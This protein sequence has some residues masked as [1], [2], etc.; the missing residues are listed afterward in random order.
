MGSSRVAEDTL[1][2]LCL[3]RECLYRCGN[4]SGLDTAGEEAGMQTELRGKM[5]KVSS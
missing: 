2:A 5:G 1:R 4:P 3:N